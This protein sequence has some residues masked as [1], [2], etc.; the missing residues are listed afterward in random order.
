[1]DALSAG[2]GDSPF[3]ESVY[4][5]RFFSDRHNVL[6]KHLQEH[7]LLHLINGS[8]SVSYFPSLP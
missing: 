8:L 3:Y 6:N 5:G 7:L 1:M 2:S 4:D